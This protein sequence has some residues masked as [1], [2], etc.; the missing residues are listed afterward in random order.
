MGKSTTAQLFA[1]AG[2][3]VWDADAAVHRL[4]AKGGA[5]VTPLGDLFPDVIENDQVSRVALR[6]LLKMQPDALRDIERIVHPLVA[7]DREAFL[8]SSLA[9]IVVLDIPLLF[10]TG[11]NTTL[12]G[13]VCVTVPAE[14]Q[15]NRVMARATMTPEAFGQILAKQMPNDEK[16]A[17]SD[18]VIV[19][20]TVEHARAQVKTVLSRI[21]ERM[22]DA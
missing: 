15:K 4:Y 16:C 18:F 6:E 17:L 13:V 22:R 10:E 14:E 19:T 11:G 2:C 8:A 20:D 21:K 7:K 3:D 12:D 9:D 5:A 1:E